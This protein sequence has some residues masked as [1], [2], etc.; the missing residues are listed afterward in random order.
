MRSPLFLAGFQLFLHEL[1]DQH[2]LA[3]REL[4]VL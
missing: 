3:Q 1:R 4:L 2:A